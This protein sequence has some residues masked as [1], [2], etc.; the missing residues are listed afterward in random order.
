MHEVEGRAAFEAVSRALAGT[1]FSAIQ[2]VERTVSTNADASDALGDERFAGRTL[3]AEHQTLGVGRKGRP[4][5]ARPYTS[6]LFTT[7]LPDQVPAAR[8]WTIPYWAAI[9]LA[10]ALRDCGIEATVMWPNDLL[11]GPRK[12]AGILCVSRVA[13][14]RAWVGIGIGINVHRQHGAERGI[15]PPPAFCDDAAPVSRPELLRAILARFDALLPLLQDPASV[16]AQWEARAS[17]P[18]RYRILKDGATLPFEAN[19]VG[20][21]EGGGLIVEHDGAREIVNLADAR[22]LR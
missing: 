6:L 10:G 14:D 8:L 21:A 13:G 17:L 16:I 1:R 4:W 19:A 22:A 5:L 20:L 11:I 9:A 15:D 7:I 18:K 2:Y 12:V 3:I